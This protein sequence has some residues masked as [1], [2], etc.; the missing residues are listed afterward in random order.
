[1]SLSTDIESVPAQGEVRQLFILLHGSGGAP[2]D[3]QGL[4]EAV[5]R[6][7]PQA[8]IVAPAGFEPY[9]GPGE[10]RQWFS[11]RGIDEDNRPAR[12][13]RALPALVAYIRACQLRFHLLQSDTALAGFSQGAIMALEATAAHDGLAGRVLAFSGRYA[14]MPHAAPQYTTIH[15]LHGADDSVMPVSHARRAQARLSELH[16]DSTIDVATHVGHELHPALIERAVVRLQTCVPLRSW[17]AA[18]GLNQA[19]PPGTLLH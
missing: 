6:A 1:M 7:F 13:A 15:L 18:L 2:A 4:A 9:D 5:R 11:T 14:A 3:M 16:G 19:A 12:V 17:E 8:A 10:G